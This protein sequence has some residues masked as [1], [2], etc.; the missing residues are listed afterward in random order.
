MGA[1]LM[2]EQI[3]PKPGQTVTREEMMEFLKP[4]V[5]KW[6]LPEGN[7]IHHRHTL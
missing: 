7:N 3:V 5:A 6:W 4:R 1:C 2:M